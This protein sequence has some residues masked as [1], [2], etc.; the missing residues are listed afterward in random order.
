PRASAKLTKKAWL[1]HS[2]CDTPLSM[3]SAIAERGSAVERVV[4]TERCLL[5]RGRC[6]ASS[7]DYLCPLRHLS[8]PVYSMHVIEQAHIGYL[9][10]VLWPRLAGWWLIKQ[11]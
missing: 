6:A 5:L 9:R 3:L 2:R 1:S 4:G 8:S 11:G 10:C 7:G